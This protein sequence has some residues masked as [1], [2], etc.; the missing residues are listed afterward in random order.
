MWW[1]GISASGQTTVVSSAH[2]R[3]HARTHTQAHMHAIT[4]TTHTSFSVSFFIFPAMCLR[5]FSGEANCILMYAL[6]II[7]A[8]TLMSYLQRLSNDSD[9]S[10]INSFFSLLS[11]SPTSLLSTCVCVWKVCMCLT[12]MWFM[13]AQS[14]YVCVPWSLYSSMS[15]KVA[16]CHLVKTYCSLLARV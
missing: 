14:Q 16:G 11:F 2:A 8:K 3:V 1:S 12:A 13:Y 4:H 7:M 9:R 15:V 5:S 10:F 6:V